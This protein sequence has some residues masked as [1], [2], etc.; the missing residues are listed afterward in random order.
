M[1]WTSAV[2]GLRLGHETNSA[3]H[4]LLRHTSPTTLP[5]VGNTSLPQMGTLPVSR[6]PHPVARRVEFHRIPLTISSLVFCGA[7]RWYGVL[8]IG[9]LDNGACEMEGRKVGDVFEAATTRFTRTLPH[10]APTPTVTPNSS[11]G[12]TTP[13]DCMWGQRTLNS[14][15]RF[16]FDTTSA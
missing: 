10:S 11:H 6:P 16:P 14:T 7:G 9:H 3:S 13:A 15:I 1:E 4:R 12:T 8:R 5:K 2:V